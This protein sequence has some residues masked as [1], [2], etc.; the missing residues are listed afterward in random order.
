MRIVR[1][2]GS[3]LVGLIG[4]GIT[5]SPTPALHE[6]EADHHG[7]RYLYRVFDL[8]TLG[9]SPAEV[10]DIVRSAALLG[11]TGLNITHPAKQVV[12][13]VLDR[14]D[15]VSEALGAVNTVVIEEDGQLVGHNT[16]VA[17]FGDALVDALGE[18]SLGR[19]LQL[20]AGGAGAATAYAVL[21]RGAAALTL[22]DVDEGRGT[23]LAAR[24][25]SL[26]PGVEVDSVAFDEVADTV[27][28]H[29]GVI[30]AS[31]V[32]SAVSP[33]L[34]LD[35]TLLHSEQ[36]VA[37][38]VYRPLRTPLVEKA[39]AL[40]CVAVGGGGMMVGQ[41]VASFTAFAGR[42]ADAARIAAHFEEL[43]LAGL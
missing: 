20:G 14:L 40:G 19:I 18:R 28:A 21:E 23:Q 27:P 13:P 37:D 17:A 43:A 35:P 12:I 25:R 9:L 38:V 2:T 7:L 30:N 4:S 16:D 31:P 3:I 24:M 6:R 22:T 29:N 42:K 11:Y 10:P 33:G 39:A 41:A 34:P 1:P 5:R 32:G 8:P 15:A 36:W 26:F